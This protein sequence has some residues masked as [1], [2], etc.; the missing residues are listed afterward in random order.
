MPKNITIS[1]PD[2]L[3]VSMKEK[4]GEFSIS[5][6]CAKALQDQV[7][8]INDHVQK[9]KIRF[10]CFNL[11]DAELLAFNEGLKWASEKAT[12]GQILY[13]SLFNEEDEIERYAAHNDELNNILNGHTYENLFEY[14]TSEISSI[15]PDY[16]ISRFM[17][18]TNDDIYIVSS[19][20]DGVKLIWE[21]IKPFAD[22]EING[23]AG[24]YIFMKQEG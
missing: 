13:I 19:F 15:F 18:E 10:A 9:A 6:T 22:K 8:G 24:A 5:Q 17:N 16:I 12:I 23:S 4:K 1:I 21:K 14:F 2:S 3:Y 20:F 7:D 11:A